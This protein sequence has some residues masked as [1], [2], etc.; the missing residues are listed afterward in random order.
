MPIKAIIALVVAVT[1][2]LLHFDT[3]DTNAS[4]EDMRAYNETA[5]QANSPVPCCMRVC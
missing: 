4:V 2:V 1:G 5:G 3:Y